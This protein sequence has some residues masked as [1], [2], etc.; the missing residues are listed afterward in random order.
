MR[1][2][3]SASIKHRKYCNTLPCGNVCGRVPSRSASFAAPIYLIDI[4]SK[5]AGRAPLHTL[6]DSWAAPNRAD[7]GLRDPPRAGPRHGLFLE[8]ELRTAL[9]RAPGIGVEGMGA[10]AIRAYTRRSPPAGVRDHFKRAGRARSMASRAAARVA[11]QKRAAAETLPGRSGVPRSAG[12]LDPGSP[13][14][15]NRA[16]AAAA[17]TPRPASQRKPPPSESALLAHLL[18]ARGAAVRG[19]R[20]VVPEDPRDDCIITSSTDTAARGRP[21][22]A[23]VRVMRRL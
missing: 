14:R 1:G 5:H 17:E 21:S 18:G 15:G 13:R 23:P 9:S 20:G 3:R 4:Y 11:S 2:S 8:R 6:C 22:K 19:N 12:E 7:V 16:T 10:A